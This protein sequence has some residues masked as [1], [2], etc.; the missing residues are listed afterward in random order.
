MLQKIIEINSLFWHVV[1]DILLHRSHC[2]VSTRPVQK[3]FRMC[4][5]S[6][7]SWHQLSPWKLRTCMA[8]TDL[9]PATHSHTPLN[10]VHNIN[11]VINL[12]KNGSSLKV[13]CTCKNAIASMHWQLHLL[14][15]VNEWKQF[16]ITYCLDA[17]AYEYK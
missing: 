5:D 11:G 8:H 9:Q 17:F 6:T 15:F 12:H 4:G 13:I 3:I 1:I 2:P 10:T 7:W 14:S 16:Q